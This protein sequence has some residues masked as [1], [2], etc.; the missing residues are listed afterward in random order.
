MI[1]SRL[2]YV[3][4]LVALGFTLGGCGGGGS[5]GGSVSVQPPP[6]P[7]AT[8][9]VRGF[10]P[11]EGFTGV[12]VTVDGEGLDLIDR[13][14]FGNTIAPM[15]QRTASSLV[16]T[17]PA[18][19]VSGPL[20]F[21][22][23]DG[24]S[25]VSLNSFDV[26]P[27]LVVSS[28]QPTAAR[29]GLT[30]NVHGEHLSEVASVT[31][32]GNLVSLLSKSA[33]ALSFAMPAGGG[34][35]KLNGRRQ[36]TISAGILTE[37]SSGVVVYGYSPASGVVGSQFSL[38]GINLDKV[39]S[40]SV[41]GVNATILSND[42]EKLTLQVPVAGNGAIVIAVEGNNIHIGSFLLI[43]GAAKANVIISRVEVAQT[44]L[45]APGQ[46]YQRL[47]PG[48]SALLNV[49]ISGAQGTAS[50]PVQLTASAGNTSLGTVQL[51]G[52]ATLSATPQASDLAQ[53]FS[54]KLPAS[55]V[56]DGVT[57]VVDVDPQKISTNGASYTARPVVGSATTFNL[58][59]VPLS[60]SEGNL[61][62]VMPDL[63][64]VR[65]LL[66][67]IFPVSESS[68]KVSQRAPY[69]L[70]SVT[71]VETSD[72]WSSALSELD[73]LRDTEGQLKHYYGLVP[74][75]NFNGGTSGLGYVPFKAAGGDS[76][77]SIGLDARQSFHLR[78]MSHE[79][80]HNLGRDHAP[81]G[82]TGT[83]DPDFPYAGGAMGPTV[84]YDNVTA[85]IA[86][87][88]RATDLMG[89][90]DGAW[91]SDY[92]Y[93]HV[94]N[95]LENWL[96]PTAQA[97]K[98]S[99]ASAQQL[100]LIEISGEIDAKGVRFQAISGSVGQPVSSKGDHQLRLT[101]RDGSQIVQPFTTVKVADASAA[102]QHFKLKLRKP[103]IEIVALEVLKAG[104]VLPSGK[105]IAAAQISGDSVPNLIWKEVGDQLQLSWNDSR[106][107]YLSVSYVNGNTTLLARQ[108][109][110]GKGQL[111]IGNLP[112][113]GAWQ[114]VLSDGLNTQLMHIKR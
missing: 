63:A 65:T 54:T 19:A 12:S 101:L 25:I 33:T 47:V 107:R 102:L 10:S 61:E 69:R 80:G 87:M 51:S 91:F 34:E 53:A 23:K 9:L 70:T 99:T 75:A 113:A 96:Y 6:P 82:V 27:N 31:V 74:N 86:V 59:L 79:L 30:I 84:V 24:K 81:C 103:S 56:R 22:K 2:R 100:E 71:K 104:H 90:C 7:Q 5:G 49:L 111:F 46:L 66:G 78:T 36:P 28:L 109:H 38:T 45:Q 58:V 98:I 14:M 40:V 18:G 3:F 43:T 76:R 4:L 41:G 39:S 95:W 21:V 11:A 20:T 77:S 112:N 32:N 94:Q 1:L 42:S 105:A 89:Y 62:A 13:V 93:F 68:I 35:V 67:K 15:T 72:E 106:Y 50:P 60:I 44:Y 108:L 48:K 57:L 114:F 73:T 52:P 16:V 85:L 55:W 88:S 26:I 37:Q 92:N 17:V 83:T 110:G 64:T 8:V 29:V 97:M